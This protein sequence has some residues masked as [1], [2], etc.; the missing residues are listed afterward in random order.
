M[1][2]NHVLSTPVFVGNLPPGP[3]TS[4]IRT[5]S[6][7][8]LLVHRPI[9]F[10]MDAYPAYRSTTTSSSC[11]LL[12]L[13]LKIEMQGYYAD[14]GSGGCLPCA[15]GTYSI[16]N[17]GATSCLLCPVGKSSI[18]GAQ[19]CTSCQPGTFAPIQGSAKCF[20]C[21]V[22]KVAP[23]AESSA[24]A[25]CPQN[26]VA[27]LPGLAHCDIECNTSLAFYS[28]PGNT[29]TICIFHHNSMPI[30]DVLGTGDGACRFCNWGIINASSS[31]QGCGIGHF[32]DAN[33]DMCAQCP[34][35]L[36]NLKYAAAEN[37]SFCT[38]C[39]SPTAYASMDA[40]S[41]I[42]ASPGFMPITN[43]TTTT[44]AQQY[45]CP[46]G[47]SRNSTQTQC[48]LCTF[49]TFASTQGSTQCTQCGWG[50]YSS[51]L[52]QVQCNNCPTG[53]QRIL[54]DS[55]KGGCST[56]FE[57]FKKREGAQHIL[58]HSK[59]GGCST[60]FEAFKREPARHILKHS[61]EIMLNTL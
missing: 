25:V 52:G 55:K 24:C 15:P 19:E 20:P 41:C 11:H 18:Q 48:T 22:G 5:R 36:V 35:G 23:E 40:M 58:K 3:F 16:L 6:Y 53:T 59:K 10:S 42:E 38:A 39:P 43:G 32:L 8:V 1:H 54:R 33:R 28:L 49:G 31:C 51:G 45:A 12:M 29:S 34:L 2:R 46:S 27:S 60:H 61:K 7:H 9:V 13:P 17:G 14:S 21:D 4:Q 57:G 37:E 50:S 56:H 26:W 30:Y 47:T 44:T